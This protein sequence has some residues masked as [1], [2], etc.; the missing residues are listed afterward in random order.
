ME[1]DRTGRGPSADEVPLHAVEQAPPPTEYASQ[2]VVLQPCSICGR[3]FASTRLAKHELACQ[4]SHQKR[5]T[6]DAKEQRLTAEQKQTARGSGGVSDSGGSRGAERRR[7]TAAVPKW[8]RQSE[9]FQAMLKQGRRDKQLLKQG[10][11]ARDLPQPQFPAHES[12]DDRVECPHCRRKFNQAAADRHI[13]HCSST[14]ARPGRLTRG[15]GTG[16]GKGRR[17]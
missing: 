11:S 7:D 1:T 15:G 10:V 13:P 17:N 9:A 6:F 8:K 16:G 4:K 2:D 14:K 3:K 12:S 5:K